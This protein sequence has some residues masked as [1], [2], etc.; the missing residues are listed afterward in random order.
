MN[1]VAFL[2]HSLMDTKMI[3]GVGDL[4]YINNYVSYIR[5]LR[6][7]RTLNHVSV[8]FWHIVCRDNSG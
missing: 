4:A 2:P 5:L 8:S 1:N 6:L 7:K 3:S